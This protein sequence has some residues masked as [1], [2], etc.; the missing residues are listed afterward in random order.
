MK[1][2]AEGRKGLP[3]AEIVVV[4]PARDE[5]ELIDRCLRSIV[6]S[7]RQVSVMVHICVVADGCLDQTVPIAQMIAGVNVVEID[8]SNVGTARAA[9]VAHALTLVHYPLDQVWIANTDADSEVPLGW[10]EDHLRLADIGADAV[11]GTV[12]PDFTDLTPAQVRAWLVT[13]PSGVVNGHVH[14]ANLGIRASAYQKAGGY[15]TVPE[16][17]DADLVHRLRSFSVTAECEVLTSGRRFGRTPG[18]YARYLRED[19]ENAAARRQI[20]D[21][22]AD[23]TSAV[24]P[25]L[26]PQ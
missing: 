10:L 12:R 3:V 18:G 24:S 2:N 23:A 13:H 5:E 22:S 7:A 8:S 25:G 9:G 11:V 14:G 1:C 26:A 20:S 16:H 6:E 4:V 15:R 21:P 17:E 19:L